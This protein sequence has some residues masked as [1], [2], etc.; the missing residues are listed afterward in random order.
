MQTLAESAY[1][2]A[3]KIRSQQKQLNN[4][5]ALL[6]K[7][8]KQ[9]DSAAAKGKFNTSIYIDYNLFIDIHLYRSQLKSI[10]ELPKWIYDLSEYGFSINKGVIEGTFYSFWR[11]Y[12][13]WEPTYCVTISWDLK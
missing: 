7:A 8:L 1:I 4:D 2:K 9:I 12:W 3:N 11:H 6:D 10:T 5:K 13:Y